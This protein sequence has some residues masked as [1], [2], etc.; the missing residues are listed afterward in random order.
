MNKFEHLTSTSWKWMAYSYHEKN[1]YQYKNDGFIR[2]TS[3][4]SSTAYHPFKFLKFRPFIL[5][6]PPVDLLI[7]LLN[8]RGECDLIAKC[9]FWAWLL[10]KLSTYLLLKTGM[11]SGLTL[12]SISS[13]NFDLRFTFF[14]RFDYFM[15]LVILLLFS[16]KENEFGLLSS[17][18]IFLPTWQHFKYSLASNR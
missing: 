2:L 17:S 6:F 8:L 3:W 13:C 7:V 15:K 11:F 10:V 16:T 12:L 5:A 14:F 18:S 1:K 4:F 9:C